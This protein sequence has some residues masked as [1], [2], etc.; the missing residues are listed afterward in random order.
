MDIITKQ[1]KP[2]F[3]VNKITLNLFFLI[4][5]NGYIVTRYNAFI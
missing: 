1:S 5:L 3:K 2:Q 4:K